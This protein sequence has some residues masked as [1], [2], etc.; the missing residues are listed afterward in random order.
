MAVYLLHYAQPYPAGRR[1]QHY[2]G[3]SANLPRRVAKHA[4]GTSRASLPTAMHAVGIPFTL[5]RVWPEGDLAL[6]R[7]LHGWK[8]LRVL[9]PTCRGTGTIPPTAES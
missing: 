2:L 7:R 3:Y 8:K 1:P 4:N 5:V 9:C 6:E